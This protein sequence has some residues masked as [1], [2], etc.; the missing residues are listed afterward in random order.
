MK[1]YSIFKIT[2]LVAAVLTLS[3][4]S[5][6]LMVQDGVPGNGDSF[7]SQYDFVISDDAETRVSYTDTKHSEFE[8]GDEV[9]VYVVDKDGK[10]ESGQPTN[11]SYTVRSV[12]NINDGVQRQVLQP[13]NP[14][15]AVEKNPGYRY[16][17]YYPYNP[18]MTLDRLKNYTHTVENDQNS[19]DAFEKSDL[20]WCYFTP[21][22]SEGAAYEVYFDHAMAQIIV[23]VG[24]AVTNVELLN[25]PLTA[26]SINLVQPLG[27]NFRYSADVPAYP[28]TPE[29][30]PIT[31]YY[32]GYADSGNKIFRAVVPA[33]TFDEKGAGIP[34][35]R[36]T[37]GG[38]A[39]NYKISPREGGFT[40]KAGYIYTLTLSKGE[41]TDI[42][43]SDDDSWGLDVLDPETGEPVG[44]LCREYLRYQPDN[45]PSTGE[46]LSGD[47]TGVPS[48]PANQC[49]LNS[50]AWV[51]YNLQDYTTK[52]P[53][54]SKGTVLRF[55]YDVEYHTYDLG[56]FPAP[57]H[58]YKQQ[59]IFTPEHG[60]NWGE[61]NAEGYG[62]QI[63]NSF[64]EHYMNGGTVTWNGAENKITSFVKLS[65]ADR[66]TCEE[67]KNGFIAI[68][69][70]GNSISAKVSYG[71]PTEAGVRVG[72][73]VPHNL[74]D[75]R[76]VINDD[77]VVTQE[78]NLYPLVKIGFNQFWMSKP[79]R[80][81]SLTD[82]T[83]L[84]CYNKIDSDK[85]AT[86]DIQ[87]TDVLGIGYM[88]PF[89]KNVLSGPNGARTTYDPINDPAE[90][91]VTAY[92]DVTFRPT[93]L[94]NKATIQDDRFV[95]ESNN[96]VRFYYLMPTGNEVMNMINYIGDYFAAKI[97]SRELA[98]KTNTKIDD[99]N[100]NFAYWRYEAA[101]KG[102]T[103]SNEISAFANYYT[104]NICGFNLHA[105]GF[106]CTTDGSSIGDYHELTAAACFMVKTND[107]GVECFNIPIHAPFVNNGNME[108]IHLRNQ[109]GTLGENVISKYFTQVRMMMKFR[110][111]LDNAGSALY[112]Y[113]TASSATR[114]GDNTSDSRNVRVQLVE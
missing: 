75:T 64:K 56:F 37:S 31:A 74:V 46:Y 18:N 8:E 50:Q 107:V 25:M 3:A 38:T 62:Q 28:A 113:S 33:H 86:L 78:T 82:G 114:A 105:T 110:N 99:N 85:P 29:N 15:L 21:P 42:E 79:L 111:Q 80:A 32:F 71:S 39:K 72:V 35:V 14:E 26:Y 92:P 84:P 44:L 2:A 11:V 76:K 69:G 36:I 63:Q 94:Y 55:I 73:I 108:Q 65:E 93:P 7:W 67:A 97:A 16:V 5:D 77:G 23:E 60:Y 34:A 52:I 112:S 106:Y 95:P 61:Q 89:T 1:L 70:H 10:L 51:F 58:F 57:H 41:T 43:V 24:E 17:L 4:C 100:E 91:N 90:M 66:V 13:T 101:V 103:H 59:G 83:P 27:D 102:Q 9:G 20:L 12:T 54:L 109:C 88:Y 45:L 96:P 49:W 104:A 87:N 22:S 6:E 48:E 53:D 30:T 98:T 81:K 40:F 19:H 47:E 68:T